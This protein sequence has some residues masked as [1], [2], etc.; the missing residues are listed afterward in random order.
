MG[1]I[2]TIDT[3]TVSPTERLGYWNNKIADIVNSLKIDSKSDHFDGQFL[4][5]SIGR[6]TFVR[7]KSSEA[8]V[9]SPAPG[10]DIPSEHFLVLH[11]QNDGF[12][13]AAQDDGT[14]VL[15]RTGDLTFCDNSVHYWLDLSKDNDM[16][17]ISIPMDIV[18]EKIPEALNYVMKTV[19]RTNPQVR[20]LHSFLMNLWKECNESS[21]GA[22]WIDGMEDVL[23]DLLR[24]ALKYSSE[25]A[26]PGDSAGRMQKKLL[27][28][29]H[30]RLADPKL[31]TASLAREVGI[32]VRTVQTQF[33]KLGTTPTA[34]ILKQR[35]ALAAK[36][37][38]ALPQKRITDIAYD[39]G[40]NDS[41]YFTR[42]FRQ[43]FG[44]S[45]R[46]FRAN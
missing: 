10:C 19:P 26:T 39:S 5:A 7:A 27:N 9:H 46:E 13:I 17:V 42:R 41:A 23:L 16:L 44:Q 31:S 32:S 4:H 38:R 35:L 37:L 29:I 11:L 28:C 34:Y 25:S 8:I 30:E 24:S 1:S 22:N 15:L 14:E 12:S 33:A 2:S 3:Y 45:P 20:L 6:I 18:V 21:V 40:F 43:Y 36:L